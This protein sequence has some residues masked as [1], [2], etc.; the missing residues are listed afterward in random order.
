MTD[1]A[2]AATAVPKCRCIV[3]L[4]GLPGSGKTTFAQVL[5]DE[6]GSKDQRL[7]KTVSFDNV[8]PLAE[9]KALAEGTTLGDG[10][11]KR[12]RQDMRDRVRRI[13]D[14]SGDSDVITLVDDN[15]YYRSMRYEYYQLAKELDLGFCQIYLQVS[16][17]AI[18][19][20]SNAGRPADSRVPD[21]VIRQ[22][23]SKLEAPQPLAHPWESFSFVVD[24][25]AWRSDQTSLLPTLRSV[26]EAAAASPLTEAHVP[27]HRT[28]EARHA[29][30]VACHKSFLHKVDKRLRRIVGERIAIALEQN[31]QSDA[32]KVGMDMVKI[33]TELLKQ[34]KCDGPEVFGLPD[35]LTKRIQESSNSSTDNEL[36]I[37]LNKMFDIKLGK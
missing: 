24:V 21:D 23:S 4:M 17:I 30:R 3:V 35:E 11:W 37:V 27:E 28:D 29:S 31:S 8:L 15:N 32:T 9:Q 26:V 19:L 18:A 5:S 20:R 12:A 36:D 14:Q 13:F 10:D 33:R 6:F 2:T 16:D 1:A 22:M 7:V 34:L 25:G